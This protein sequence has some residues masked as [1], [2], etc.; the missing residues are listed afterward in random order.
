MKR[1]GI[2]GGGQL[3]MLLS[4]SILRLGAE[5]IIYDPDPS[6][7]ACRGVK[8][9]INAGWHDQTAIASFFANCDAVTYEFENVPSTAIA[10]SENERLIF[11]RLSVLKTTQ[12]RALEKTFLKDQHLP[13]VNFSVVSKPN[14]LSKGAEGLTFPLILK[15]VVG[16][17]DGKFQYFIPSTERL[18]ELAVELT[19][20]SE[21]IFPVTLEEALDLHLEVSCIT[22]R[23]AKGEEIAFPVLENLHADHI[24]DTTLIPARI[25]LEI[26]KKLLEIALTAARKLDVTG[27]LCT[28]FFVT[29]KDD[30]NC[31][32]V[33][34]GDFTIYIN[35]FAP[36]PHNSG[37]VTMS[38]CSLSQFDALARI[39]LGVPLSKPK[40]LAPGYFC[41]GNLLG[42][43]WLQQGQGPE[44]QLDLTALS[45]SEQVIDIVIYGKAEAR[46]KRKMGHFVTYSLD[47]NEAI[48]SARS[49]R[50]RLA[51]IE[52]LCDSP[53]IIGN[54]Y[55]QMFLDS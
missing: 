11:P 42:D 37:H 50:A 31:A 44:A 55:E 18:S 4:Q 41:M 46:S 13:H 23:S 33:H 35:E 5:A 52:P 27:L 19:S 48:A 39:L 28:E 12:N 45:Q 36:R 51:K 20:G 17:Y 10:R 3:G 15:S 22:A 24:L 40:L 49:F 47:A 2:L 16:G 53:T 30:R 43:V 26:E 8:H 54:C 32:G 29:R 25:P 7:P 1:V 14:Q 6:A 9:S 34:C 38:A 21:N